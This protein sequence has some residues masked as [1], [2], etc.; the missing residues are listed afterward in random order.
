MRLVFTGFSG[1]D[2]SRGLAMSAVVAVVLLS[3]GVLLL[4]SIIVLVAQHAM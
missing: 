4:F 2:S 3:V 1:C